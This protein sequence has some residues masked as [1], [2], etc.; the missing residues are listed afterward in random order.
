LSRNAP[1]RFDINISIYDNINLERRLK[2]RY[3]TDIRQTFPAKVSVLFFASFFKEK[4][5]DRKLEFWVF[6]EGM[7]FEKN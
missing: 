2:P 1:P 5:E 7:G 6:G 3:Q 4:K